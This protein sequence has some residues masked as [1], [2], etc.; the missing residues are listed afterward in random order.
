MFQ[1]KKDLKSRKDIL[2]RKENYLSFFFHRS[3]VDS[4]K[5]QPHFRVLITAATGLCGSNEKLRS[6]KNSSEMGLRLI[7][8]CTAM[9]KELV[10][11]YT[12]AIWLLCKKP[13]SLY[14][15]PYKLHWVTYVRRYSFPEP[16][17]KGENTSIHVAS[18]GTCCKFSS[19]FVWNLTEKK[20]CA[21]QYHTIPKC[22]KESAPRVSSK[23][24]KV[25][26]TMSSK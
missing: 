8:Q 21:N 9:C 20:L 26:S 22:R 19:K 10:C 14:V 12:E 11:Q 6:P 2:L 15:L 24:F 1:K 17:L 4:R 7:A 5:I 3:I 16:L 18:N 23:D 25:Q 13:H